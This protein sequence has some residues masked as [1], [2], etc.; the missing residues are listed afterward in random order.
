ME[1]RQNYI[2][3]I[4]YYIILFISNLLN[5]VFSFLPTVSAL[6]TILGYNTDAALV[7]AVGSFNSLIQSIWPLRDLFVAAMFWMGYLALKM[8]LRFLLGS[9]AP[10]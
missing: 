4:F 10:S 2:D 1:A 8:M 7:Q 3:M 6:P 9:R 5:A